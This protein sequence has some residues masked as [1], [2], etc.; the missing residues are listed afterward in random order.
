MEKLKN[1]KTNVQCLSYNLYYRKFVEKPVTIYKRVALYCYKPNK[2][3]QLVAYDTFVT[4][5]E[6]NKLI[7]Y[8][9]EINT[10]VRKK[11]GYYYSLIF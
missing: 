3:G 6:L 8:L 1:N 5:E 4:E 11:R 9:K 10:L 7:N 2:K